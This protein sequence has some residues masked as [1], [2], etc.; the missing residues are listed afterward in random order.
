VKKR[1]YAVTRLRGHAVLRSTAKL[2][3]RETAQAKFN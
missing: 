1:G 3:N 2:R